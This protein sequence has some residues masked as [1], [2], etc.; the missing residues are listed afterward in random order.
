MQGRGMS[1]A[2]VICAAG[3]SKR[4]GG[5]K[6]EYLRLNPDAPG[7]K[8][9]TVLGAA[10][11][12]FA[13]CSEINPIVIVLPDEAPAGILEELRAI[14][15]ARFLFA[16]GGQTRRASVFN[17]LLL[18][19]K[20]APSHVL[21]HDGAR[22]RI[23]KSLIEKVIGAML[24]HGAAIPALPMTETPKELKNPL[25]SA[26]PPEAAADNFVRRH[27]KRDTLCVAQTPQ[28]FKFPE[29]LMAHEKAAAREEKESI[30]YTDDAEIWG[31]F[32]GEVAVI[33]GDPENKKITYQEDIANNK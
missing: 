10:A 22:P 7:E 2:A 33:P 31:E 15:P 24:K 8:P 9:V 6:K 25:V 14:D 19:E 4:M 26:A 30:E 23:T 1:I 12:A 17:A 18:L 5:R 13:S 11:A 16:K 32:V 3:S 20:H 28:G 27:L 29:I 21:I